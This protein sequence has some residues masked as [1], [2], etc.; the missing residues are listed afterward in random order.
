MDGDGG[1]SGG[2]ARGY[3]GEVKG[4]HNQVGCVCPL[5]MPHALYHKSSQVFLLVRRGVGQ[6]SRPETNTHTYT[7]T[8]TGTQTLCSAG[9]KFDGKRNYEGVASVVLMMSWTPRK[10]MTL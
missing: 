9:D 8:H 10:D 5:P 3:Q 7:E 2:R 4:S 1:G 6:K